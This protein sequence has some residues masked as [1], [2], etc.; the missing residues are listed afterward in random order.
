MW[1][2]TGNHGEKW[3]PAQV[4]WPGAKGIQVRT[5]KGRSNALTSLI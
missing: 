2:M 1:H 5:E 3:L 4:A